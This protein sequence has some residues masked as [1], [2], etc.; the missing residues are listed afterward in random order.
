[1]EYPRGIIAL[2]AHSSMTVPTIRTTTYR[3]GHPS[4]LAKS[5]DKRPTCRANPGSTVDSK[6]SLPETTGPITNSIS[7]S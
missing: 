5:P 4:S 1:M 2:T 6:R 3:G 7:R